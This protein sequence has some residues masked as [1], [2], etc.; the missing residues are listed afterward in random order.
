MATTTFQSA[1]VLDLFV[2]EIFA[3][4]DFSLWKCNRDLHP[5]EGQIMVSQHHRFSLHD[6][7]LW[8]FNRNTPYLCLH[9]W[10]AL[11]FLQP[12]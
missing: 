4:C 6:I 2:S 11:H 5:A 1:F 9:M 3:F 12:L 7:I 10:D 8:K